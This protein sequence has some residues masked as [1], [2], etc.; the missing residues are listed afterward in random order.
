MGGRHGEGYSGYTASVEVFP[1]AQDTCFIPDLPGPRYDHSLSLLSGG[2]LVV[3]GGQTANGWVNSCISWIAG[4]TSWTPFHTMRCLIPIMLNN[5]FHN[6]RMGRHYHT[7]W[8]PPS[9]PNSIVLLGGNSNSAKLT[10][11]IVPGF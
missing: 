10:A 7:A 6:H 9:L 5:H 11:E 2:S 1:P 8:T 4:N 3:C